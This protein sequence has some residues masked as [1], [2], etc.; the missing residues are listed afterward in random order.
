MAIQDNLQTKVNKTK[1]L[2]YLLIFLSTGQAKQK[3]EK[4]KMQGVETFWIAKPL[5]LLRKLFDRYCK[6]F[7]MLDF[8]ISH[9]G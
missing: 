2:I 5:V 4:L 9:L 3:G 7:T 6:Q 8:L 1:L